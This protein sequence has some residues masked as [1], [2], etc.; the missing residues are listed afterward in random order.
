[1]GQ[2]KEQVEVLDKHLEKLPEVCYAVND[3]EG[4]IV[5][6]TKLVPGYSPYLKPEGLPTLRHLDAFAMHLNS[7]LGVSRRQMNAMVFGS[8][9][10]WFAGAAD[11]DHELNSLNEKWDKDMDRFLR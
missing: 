4:E 5:I 8:M 2:F 3:A 11:P 10:D 9:F 1:M 7:K 6:I